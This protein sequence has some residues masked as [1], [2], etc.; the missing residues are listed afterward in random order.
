MIDF[1][2]IAAVV[3]VA[4]LYFVKHLSLKTIEADAKATYEK[5]VSDLEAATAKVEAEAKSDVARVVSYLK[6]KF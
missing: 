2:L 5:A 4:Y 6:A 3:V 1:I